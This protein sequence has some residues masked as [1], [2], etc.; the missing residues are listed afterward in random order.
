MTEPPPARG[1]SA[2]SIRRAIGYGLAVSLLVVILGQLVGLALFVAQGANGSYVPYLRIGAVYVELF[3]HVPVSLETPREAG[4]APFSL[5]VGVALM[6]VTGMAVLLL[7]AAGRRL[8]SAASGGA[9]VTGVVTTAGAYAVLPGGLAFAAR[10]PVTL[11]TGIG[12]GTTALAVSVSVVGAFAA[13]FAIAAVAVVLGALSSG[14]A[15][16]GDAAVGDVVAGG[17]RAFTIVLGLS[18]V[19]LLVVA[20]VEPDFVRAYR[21]VILAPDSVKGR[22]VVA[23]HAALLLPNQAVWVAVPAMGAC[24]EAV[25]NGRSEPVLCYWRFPTNVGLRVDDHGRVVPDGGNRPLPRWYL[26]FLFVPALG[27]VSGGARASRRTASS[28]RRAVTG[29]AG[30]IVFAALIAIAI[31]LARID[32]RATGGLLDGQSYRVTLG[33]ELLRGTAVA[34]AWGVVGGAVGGLLARRL[35]GADTT[36]D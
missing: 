22:A 16:S 6:L 5:D 17:A 20:G 34:A 18:I 14:A 26:A 3:H 35:G 27:T 28:R 15:E 12:L 8:G 32:L 13:P 30:G 36:V 23:G 11:P 10:G 29:A 7:A 33:P 31:A 19:G 2:P 21:A 4:G 1:P 24:D 9:T 25:A